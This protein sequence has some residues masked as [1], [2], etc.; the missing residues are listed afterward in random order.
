ALLLLVPPWLAA[1]EVRAAAGEWRQHPASAFARVERARD[2]NPLTDW[3]DVI[4]GAIASR[5]GDDRLVIASFRRA[6]DRNP[7][8]WYSHLELA[9]AY[10]RMGE[11]APALR[12]LGFAERLDPLE[13]TI[14]FVRSRL[15]TGR[16]VQTQ[17]L[18]TIFLRRTF[19]SNRG[20][21]K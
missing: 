12:E 19:V 3:P 17:E 13:P 11:K 16:P 8:N 2:L 15:R 20:R 18:D 9:V 6:L 1:T 7:T 4:A 21:P 14:P 10:G 5:L